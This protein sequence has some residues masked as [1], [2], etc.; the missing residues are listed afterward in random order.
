MFGRCAGAFVLVAVVT[1]FWAVGAT[2]TATDDA[3]V[4]GKHVYKEDVDRKV[5]L[6]YGD[7]VRIGKLDAEGT[8]VE[9]YKAPLINKPLKLKEPVYE[10]RSGV[11]VR[12]ILN[13]EGDF[14]PDAGDKSEIIRFKD[15]KYTKDALRIYNLPGK[16]VEKPPE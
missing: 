10:Y 6:V 14:V 15:Y 7:R 8:F 9:E 2:T 1:S 16:F 4:A 13:D 12:G 11:L 5:A 3:K